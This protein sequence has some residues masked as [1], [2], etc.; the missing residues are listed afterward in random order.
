MWK[1]VVVAL[2]I[3]LAAGGFVAW[4]AQGSA[5]GQA[6]L[7]T[8]P[9]IRGELLATISATGTLEPE[10]VIDVG[11]QVAGQIKEFGSDPRTSKA[12]DYGS[13]VEAG[14][15]LARID[16]SLYKAKVEQSKARLQSAEAKVDQARANV[17][18]AEADLT[19]S[20]ARLDQAERDWIRARQLGPQNVIS[21]QDYDTAKA[22]YET[23]AAAVGVSEASLV[24]ARAA[25][26]DAEAAVADARA[27]LRQDEINL[28]YC[29]I[30][31]PVKGVI[32]DRRVTL[33]QTVQSS[34]NTPSLFLI[35]KD[36][37]RMTV[38]ASV[39]EADVGQVRVGQKVHF[40]VDAFPGTTFQGVVSRIRLNA[41][42]T[43]NVVTYTVE[44]STDNAD[45]RLLPY[46]TANLHFE[47]NRKDHALLVPNAALRW[48]PQPNQV[49]PEDRATYVQSMR[50]KETEAGSQGAANEALVWVLDG[51][52]VRPVKIR[53]GLTDGNKTEVVDGDLPENVRVVIGE[54]ARVGN[55]DATNPFAPKLFGGKKGS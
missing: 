22:T 19:Q 14:T 26:S 41:T 55:T 7:R 52:Y 49:A 51:A 12:I 18:R 53:L 46:L 1:K 36:L 9:V 35:A 39:N 20:K 29:T 21:Q 2:L 33:G 8:E 38:W 13:E 4:Y 48:K 30:Q 17:K 11:A 45:G 32:I 40:T 25:V 42:M 6:T 50:G 15:V 10:D 31:S 44:V 54:A 3:V 28:G 43:Q 24:Q 5:K 27:A 23:S 37:K 47:V 16:D 34:F